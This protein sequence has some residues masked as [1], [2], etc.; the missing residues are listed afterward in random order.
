M[1]KTLLNNHNA[2]IFDTTIQAYSESD[3]LKMSKP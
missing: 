2:T 3:N 1:F